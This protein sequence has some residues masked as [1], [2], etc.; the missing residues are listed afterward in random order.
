MDPTTTKNILDWNNS[1]MSTL[2]DAQSEDQMEF[3]TFQHRYEELDHF[4]LGII[5]KN[6]S[7]GIENRSISLSLAENIESAEK[8]KVLT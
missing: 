3:S 4:A 2:I 6:L 8:R 1:D 7:D 5:A